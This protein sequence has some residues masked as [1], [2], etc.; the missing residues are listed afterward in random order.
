MY[1]LKPN[2]NAYF[3]F[4]VQGSDG[5]K[6]V[7]AN[8]TAVATLMRN[9]VATAVTVT[10]TKTDGN[11][12]G[13]FLVPVGYVEEDA[14]EVLASVTQNSIVGPAV[15]VFRAKVVSKYASDVT[16]LIGLDGQGLVS[17]GLK[18]TQS[19]N[20][21]GQSALIPAQVKGMDPDTITAG[22]VAQSAVDEIGNPLAKDA[23]VA[24]P[25]S[26]MT[27]TGGERTAIANE[28]EA[29]IIDDTDSEK[30]LK[31]ITDK[32]AAA[33]PDL[34]G[35]TLASIAARVRTELTTELA[36]IVALEQRLTLNRSQLLDKL[37]VS[38]VLA[39]TNNADTFKATGFATPQNVVDAR[40]TVTGA[41][42]TSQSTVVQTIN[43]VPAATVLALKN[44]AAHKVGE[45][46]D[47]KYDVTYPNNTTVVLTFKNSS[48]VTLGTQTNTYDGD[49]KLLSRVLTVN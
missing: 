45:M 5:G 24:K 2:T 4:P 37:N 44:D 25:G 18:S 21:T 48:N 46:L 43:T 40:D 28:V 42:T 38:G 14:L 19:F 9:N 3:S 17:V 23:T 22:A 41:I 20:N 33:N 7:A 8:F 11:V 16:T 26:A 49:G 10:L 6:A 31:A 34:S 1:L 13:T 27:L 29:Q 47:A 36:D 30:V 32:I 15:P 39:N 35:L 12:A